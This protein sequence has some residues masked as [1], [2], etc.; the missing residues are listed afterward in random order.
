MEFAIGD[1]VRVSEDF[2]FA[3]PETYT[4]SEIREDGTCTLDNGIDFAP[5]HLIKV[6]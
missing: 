6:T 2:A 5:E 3:L 1:V 4:I